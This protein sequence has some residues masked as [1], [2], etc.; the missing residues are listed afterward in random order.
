[1]QALLAEPAFELQVA[2]ATL[3]RR[4]VM[5]YLKLAVQ[6]LGAP[7][8]S[9]VLLLAVFGGAFASR[10]SG[11]AGV[12]YVRFLAPGLIAM[13][14][15]LAAFQNPLFSIV[16]MKY[17]N[18]LQDLRQ[19]PLP[20]SSVFLAF[21]LAAALR[22]LLVGLMTYAAAGWFGGY[23]LAHP[24]L[25]WGHIGV[26]SFACAAAGLAA[27]LWLDSYER[28]NFVV[29]FTV[30]PALF[31][32]GVFFEPAASSGVLRLLARYDPVTAAIGLG[33]RLYLGAGT[34]DA[35]VT[36]LLGVVAAVLAVA[37]ALHAVRTG[38]GMKAE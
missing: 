1:V 26:A 27:G 9:N 19:Y 14:A 22:G 33:R 16:A 3:L 4:E 20:P 29:S 6:T 25:F 2:F 35:G 8:L 23:Q 31:L 18:T 36:V 12:S 34:L 15:M 17:Q 32:G 24:L 21:T 13:G 38:K 37:A 7:F 5:R 30:S 11:V 28:A 10:G